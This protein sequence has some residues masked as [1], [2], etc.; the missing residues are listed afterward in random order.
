MEKKF[1]VFI[2]STFLDLQGERQQ[3]IQAL[4]ELDCMP[5]GMELFPASDQSKW[6]LITRVI[7]GCDYYLVIIG[8]R[9]GSVD[10]TGTSYTERE[11]DYA[12]EKGIPALA[13]LH[14]K[15]DAI[16]AG[17]TE[18]KPEVRVKLDAFRRKAEQR[19]CKYWNT[20]EE[21]GAVISRSLYQ[22]MK[23]QPRAGWV[24]ADVTKTIEEL[25]RSVSS[26]VGDLG[27][28]LKRASVSE[29]Q[30]NLDIFAY[31]GETFA[32]PLNDLFETLMLVDRPPQINIRI[33]LKDWASK[34]FLPGCDTVADKAVLNE[35][36]KY[37]KDTMQAQIRRAKE[38]RSKL[39]GWR[40][41]KTLDFT[42]KLK[43]Y[44]I[45]P[46]HKG[47]LINGKRGFWSLYPMQPVLSEFPNILDYEGK[48]VRFAEFRHDGTP[49]EREAL[50]SLCKWFDSVWGSCCSSDFPEFVSA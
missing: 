24:R 29:K 40:K 23:V 8:G 35:K 44:H 25:P 30:L 47:I 3:V 11:Y 26:V 17:K 21:L 9:Y 31:S 20:P 14:A 33:L 50:G 22:T 5:I 46:F 4:L 10:E 19:M 38:L 1:Q 43:L 16:P 48:H 15:P 13:F 49:A 34:S 42:F 36:Q 7:E 37:R 45:D 41:N 12:V 18:L 2:S 27:A 6:S 39:D 32:S 28:E